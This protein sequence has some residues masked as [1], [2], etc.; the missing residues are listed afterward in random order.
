MILIIQRLGLDCTRSACFHRDQVRPPAIIFHF[1]EIRTG[2][3]M[4]FGEETSLVTYETIDEVEHV[5]GCEPVRKLL[6][7]A[8]MLPEVEDYPREVLPDIIT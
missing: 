4:N 8:E 6:P 2:P 3:R 1:R 5:H 7:G